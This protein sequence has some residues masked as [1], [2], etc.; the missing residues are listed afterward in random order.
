MGFEKVN[1]RDA[2][3]IVTHSVSGSVPSCSLVAPVVELTVAGTVMGI[4]VLHLLPPAVNTVML[5]ILLPSDVA[6]HC[7]LGRHRSLAWR[8]KNAWARSS[9]LRVLNG[10][11]VLHSN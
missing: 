9:C 10:H 1:V 5:S 11:V 8:F 6:F 3:L 4:V 2:P 7:M